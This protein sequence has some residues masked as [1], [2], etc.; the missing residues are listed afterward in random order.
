MALDRS[1]VERNR[2]Q[3]ER[4]R[5]LVAGLSDADFN[6]RVGEHWNVA[7]TLAHL[8]FWDSRVLWV[9]DASEREGKVTA[10]TI[11]TEVNDMMLPLLYAIPAHE[12]ARLAIEMAEKLD[13]RLESYPPDLLEQIA[14]FNLRYVMRALHRGEHLDEVDQALKA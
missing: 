8:A 6:R 12:A 5:K 13:A 7:V 4:I 11:A 10:P 9:L 2:V 1:F 14:G 3:T